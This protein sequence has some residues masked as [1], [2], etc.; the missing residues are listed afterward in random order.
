MLEL[1][2]ALM[3]RSF[4]ETTA[5]AP[6]P[7]APAPTPVAPLAPITPMQEP[8]PKLVAIADIWAEYKALGYEKVAQLLYDRG[9]YRAKSKD[10]TEH[11]MN[12]GTLM[13]MVKRC[14]RLG[15]L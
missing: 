2:C 6:E 14:E 8:D 11:V 3:E 5:P 15:L 1:G 9:I 4:E 7:P 13:K 10:G 12:R